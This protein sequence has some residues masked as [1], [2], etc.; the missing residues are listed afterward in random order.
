MGI[1]IV[2]K[3]DCIITDY[4]MQSKSLV[5]FGAVFLVIAAVYAIR[6]MGATRY[7]Q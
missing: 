5:G 6:F 1:P 4:H 2:H 3:I 7:L